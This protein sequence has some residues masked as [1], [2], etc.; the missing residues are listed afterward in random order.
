MPFFLSGGDKVTKCLDGGRTLKIAD[1][2]SAAAWA[3][4]GCRKMHQ[5]CIWGDGMVRPLPNS[6]MFTKVLPFEGRIPSHVS[7]LPIKRKR[8]VVR[9]FVDRLDT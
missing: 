8:S 2:T 3:P 1:A 4:D 6:L 9:H 5:T 7:Y